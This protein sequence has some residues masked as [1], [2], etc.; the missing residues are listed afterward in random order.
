MAS[1]P[2]IE[3]P[4]PK[5]PFEKWYRKFSKVSDLTHTQEWKDIY[6]NYYQFDNYELDIAI[7]E[8]LAQ[9]VT[10][11]AFTMLHQLGITEVQVLERCYLGMLG[12]NA[13]VGPQEAQWVVRR[14][15]ELCNWDIALDVWPR[16]F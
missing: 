8:D 13:I 3:V 16:I 5:L 2:K 15:A 14:L 10:E 1:Q 12:D 7:G 9:L 6:S 11:T 4:V